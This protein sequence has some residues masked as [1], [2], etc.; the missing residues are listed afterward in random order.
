RASE[1]SF[2][3]VVAKAQAV[4][5]VAAEGEVNDCVRV[6]VVRQSAVRLSPTARALDSHPMSE[7]AHTRVAHA[8]ADRVEA[9]EVVAP[10]SFKIIFV[11]RRAVYE[12]ES[13]SDCA[14]AFRLRK[15]RAGPER[16]SA[17]RRLIERGLMKRC[18]RDSS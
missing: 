7:T 1:L 15:S 8:R 4:R 14:R 2:E 12:F 5:R 11:E 18:I 17:F 3:F 13:A 9:P 6:G 16:A 10:I